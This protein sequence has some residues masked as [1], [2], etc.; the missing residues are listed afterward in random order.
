MYS[1]FALCIK[2]LKTAQKLTAKQ[3]CFDLTEQFLSLISRTSTSQTTLHLTCLRI[4]VN[5]I[6]LNRLVVATHPYH[7]ETLRNLKW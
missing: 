7:V 6:L 1:V 5:Q 4:Q 3:R 2:C